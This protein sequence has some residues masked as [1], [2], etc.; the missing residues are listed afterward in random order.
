MINLK[1]KRI[2]VTQAADFM[3]PAI[4]ETL[5]ELGAEVIANRKA[6]LDPELPA[7]IIESAGAIDALVVNLA[8]NAPTTHADQV[9]ESKWREVFSIMVDP[10]PRHVKAVVPTMRNRG[11]GKTLSVGVLKH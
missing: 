1:N 7:Q 11:G 4:C 2:L 9:N 5:S 3:G 10:L 8:V 6:L